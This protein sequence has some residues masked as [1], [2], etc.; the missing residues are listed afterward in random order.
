MRFI[1][2][3]AAIVPSLLVLGYAI[4]KARGSWR[5]EAMW[6]AFAVG[7]VGAFVAAAVEVAIAAVI[8][9]HS[10]SPTFNAAATA[11]F[12]AAIPE[13]GIKF[14]ILVKLAEKHVDVRRLQDLIILGAAVSLG[15]AALENFGN[16]VLGDWKFVA[17]VRAISAVPG[18]GID[19]ISMGALL[20]LARLHKHD[21]WR[22]PVALIVPILLHAAYD[23]PLLATKQYAGADFPV[24]VFGDHAFFDGMW[25]LV[26]TFSSL[27]VVTLCNHVLVEIRAADCARGRDSDSIET[28]DHF[29]IY[30]I[31]A[32]VAGPLLA[33]GAVYA[34]QLPDLAWSALPLAIFPIVMG[35]DA[36]FTGVE[37]KIAR[38]A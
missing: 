36:I 17:A 31:V 22:L 12:V 21:K 33:V 5:S 14:L 4:A 27:L 6:N 10:A 9:V 8:P 19:G 18:H 32:V 30:G 20:A 15:L 2:L 29:V 24:H 16:V 11:L 7:A 38:A 1:I 3:L 35:L 13:E 26:V 34:K 25:A 28:S 37:R 23:F